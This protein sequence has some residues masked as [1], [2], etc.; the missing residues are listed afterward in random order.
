MLPGK[1]E[2]SKAF[3]RIF[4]GSSNLISSAY[5]FCSRLAVAASLQ[6]TLVLCSWCETSNIKEVGRLAAACRWDTPPCMTM[7]SQYY[8]GFGKHFRP[9][10]VLIFFTVA[11]WFLLL[12]AFIC[13]VFYQTASADGQGWVVFFIVLQME[14][15]YTQIFAIGIRYKAD[16]S[17]K[18]RAKF[19]YV[20]L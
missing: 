17:C 2:S 10:G 12:P 11:S 18:S 14:Q 9:F 5:F 7:L 4:L 1:G 6:D 15:H 16:Q 19:F 3:N 13:T 20:L 8:Q